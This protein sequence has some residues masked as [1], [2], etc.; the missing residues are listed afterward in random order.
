MRNGLTI[1]L[2]LAAPAL[3]AAQPARTQVP[4]L[5]NLRL[6]PSDQ[7]EVVHAELTVALHGESL[8]LRPRLELELRRVGFG[9]IRTAMV[10]F[11][12]TTAE[13]T[14]TGSGLIEVELERPLARTHQLSHWLSPGFPPG[15]VAARAVT[16]ERSVADIP[17]IDP[18]LVCGALC[19][20]CYDLVG[21]VGYT[22]EG[23][24]I[25]VECRCTG[26]GG[27]VI[28]CYFSAPGAP[29]P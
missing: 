28:G 14:P 3:L 23:G 26:T 10:S 19:S 25:V 22:C 2:L 27:C 6:V 4:D 18:N 9:P 17:G 24:T 21:I 7:V 16:V 8:Q 13:G 12:A 1:I 11:H 5:A 15:R 20:R 29:I